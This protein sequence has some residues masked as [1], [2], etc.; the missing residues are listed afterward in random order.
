L[1]AEATAAEWYENDVLT[2]TIR[3]FVSLLPE[4]PQVLD[5][6]CGPGHESMR[7]ASTGAE[8][9]G[10][11]FSAECIR[12]ARERCPQ[13]RFEVME[14][15][16]IDDRRLGKFDGV[17]ASGS[18]IHTPVEELPAILEKLSSVLK[19][20]GHFLAI[21]RDGAGVRETWPVVD[22][23]RLKRSV[24][25]FSKETLMSCASR[26][27]YLREATLAPDLMEHGW[28]SHVFVCESQVH[29]GQNLHEK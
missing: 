24:Y 11:D 18:L 27:R 21:V 28:R 4:K 12:I 16:E 17:F 6:G 14:Y 26:F 8:V 9:V 19:E 15:E 3:D 22:G 29:P 2:P 23:L 20:D 10:I 25:R 1:T 7:L 13:C 5:V